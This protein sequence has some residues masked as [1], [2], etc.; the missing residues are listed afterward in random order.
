[1]CITP[2]LRQLWA[3]V[4]PGY[5]KYCKISASCEKSLFWLD[6]TQSDKI[7]KNSCVNLYQQ[8]KYN[9]GGVQKACIT[10]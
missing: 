3:L 6:P 9:G 8:M 2:T 7:P 10:L 5:I 1:M 4:L